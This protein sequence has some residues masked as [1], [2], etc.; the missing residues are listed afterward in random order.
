MILITGSNG[1]IG[2]AFA[3]GCDRTGLEWKPLRYQDIDFFTGFSHD[4]ELVINCAAFIPKPSVSLCDRF[5]SETIRGNVLIPSRLTYLCSEMHIPIAHIST[6]YLWN[7]DIEHTE[8]DPPQRAFNGYCGFYIGTKVIAEEEVR[9]YE[10]HFIWR[11]SLAFDDRDN[12]RNYLSK[13]A[14]FNEVF[15]RD[16]CVSHRMDFVRSC[17]D[18]WRINAQ[19][20]TY[21]VMNP[22][23]IRATKIVDLLRRAGIRS[24]DPRVLIGGHDNSKA[25]VKKLIDAGISIRSSEEAIADS[26]KNWKPKT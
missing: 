11:L 25:S 17:L 18:L 4:V 23:S 9:K 6:G 3:E 13:L 5:P 22:G 24:T 15:D 19:F 16:N 10:R 14:T 20:G 12:D 8:D 7:D 2:S 21:N 1:Y 26:I